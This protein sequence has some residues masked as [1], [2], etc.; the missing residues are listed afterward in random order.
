MRHWRKF[1]RMRRRE[2]RRAEA[3]GE[4][5]TMG[6]WGHFDRWRS[7]YR[8][9][10]DT[11]HGRVAGVC[12]GIADYIGVRRRMVRIAAILGLVFFFVPTILVYLALSFLLPKKPPELYGSAEE[13]V[14]WRGVRTAPDD[15]LKALARTFAELEERLARMETAVISADFDLHRKFRD[16][17]G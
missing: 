4:R 6:A 7:P 5:E 15:S 9:Y 12:A 17:G 8:L 11:E 2:E 16:I 3:R 14:F 1:E 13:E 10:R